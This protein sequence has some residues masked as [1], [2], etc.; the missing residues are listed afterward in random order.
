MTSK[1]D[2]R[3]IIRQTPIS[4]EVLTQTGKTLLLLFLILI[5]ILILV[6]HPQSMQMY[7]LEEQLTTPC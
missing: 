2:S 5:L 4:V 6:P 7:L 3:G 1:V